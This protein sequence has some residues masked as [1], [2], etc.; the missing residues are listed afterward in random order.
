MRKAFVAVHSRGAC[1]AVTVQVKH[2]LLLTV[3]K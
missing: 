3:E 1:D 2:P